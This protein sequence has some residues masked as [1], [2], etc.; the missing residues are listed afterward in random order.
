VILLA[1]LLPLGGIG[2]LL[3]SRL[4]PQRMGPLS[5][6]MAIALAIVVSWFYFTVSEATP[7]QATPGK[8]AMGIVVTDVSGKRVSLARANARYWSRFLSAA[9]LFGGFLM[10]ALSPKR[11]ALHDLVAGT[12]VLKATG[13]YPIP[14]RIP[15]MTDGLFEDLLG[16]G[17]WLPGG[18]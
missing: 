1:L 15:S 11:R 13:P 16:L 8:R 17:P 7:R 9:C 12:L 5:L 6:G 3:I 10:V 2:A 4:N 18:S 14:A